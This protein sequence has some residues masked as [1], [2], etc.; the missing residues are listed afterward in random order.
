[1]CNRL[2][3]LILA[4]RPRL[5]LSGKHCVYLRFHVVENVDFSVQNGRKSASMKQN[6]PLNMT[7]HRSSELERLAALRAYNILD[8]PAEKSF[9]D[10]TA[11]ASHA[12]ETPIAVISLVDSDRQ[13]FKSKIGLQISE[14]KR[15]VS[16]CHHAI[17]QSDLFVVRDAHKDSRFSANPLVTGDPKV[18]F[19]AAAPV[20]SSD[21]RHALGTICVI[22]RVARELT[23]G[24]EEAL[25]ALGRQV[26]AQLELRLSLNK[27]K[28]L[29]RI[30][31]LTGVPN[32]R[33]FYEA[34]Q[35]ERHRLKRHHRPVTLVYIDLDHFKEVNDNFGHQAGDSVLITVA[36]VMSKNLRQGDLVARLG[37]DEFALL[38]PEISAE[39]ACVAVNKIH[40]RLIESMKDNG[41]PITFS[42]GTVTFL[43][44]LGG[45]EDLLQKA[46]EVMYSVKTHG[47]SNVRCEVVES[48][49]AAELHRAAQP[50]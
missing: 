7:S 2:R 23:P 39:Q 26:Q 8:T 9:D 43:H 18:R 42:I 28:Q 15:D 30:D 14:T 13:W 41:L 4:S 24:Q 25:R 37:G 1:M 48:G 34:L 40:S 11:L 16:F 21:G 49:E 17:Q 46:D 50:E 3:T 45:I 47:K 19:Y 6:S 44:P 38:L 12:C 32:R 31:P 10:L 33:A 36:N 20:F 27:E 22:D 29:A 35:R 5:T